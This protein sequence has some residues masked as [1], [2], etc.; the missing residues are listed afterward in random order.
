MNQKVSV[1]LIE[2]HLLVRQGVRSVLEASGETEVVAEA[3]SAE[4]GL[5]LLGTTKCQVVILDL[6]LPGQNGLWCAARVRELYPQLPVLILSLHTQRSVVLD[7]VKAGARGFVAKSAPADELLAAVRTLAAGGSYFDA[8]TTPAVL[9][10]MRGEETNETGLSTREDQIL[11]LVCQG[12][13]NQL[14]AQQMNLSLSSI[15][16]HIRQLFTRF[17]VSDRSALVS[18]CQSRFRDEALLLPKR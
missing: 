14:I 5:E 7:G 2:D 11:R 4:E 16:N 10:L 12:L 9:A 1:V 15:K 6:S 18:A 13:S 8:N 17:G 3:G